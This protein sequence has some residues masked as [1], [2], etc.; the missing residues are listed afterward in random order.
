MDREEPSLLFFGDPK[1]PN[2]SKSNESQTGSLDLEL[3]VSF[4]L[5]LG[6]SE[7]NHRNDSARTNTISKD[8][9]DH[10]PTVCF[11]EDEDKEVFQ[12]ASDWPTR[13]GPPPQDAS[14]CSFLPG[15]LWSPRN[16]GIGK[17]QETPCKAVA[18]RVPLVLPCGPAVGADHCVAIKSLPSRTIGGENHRIYSRPNVVGLCRKQVEGERF[19]AVRRSRLR[20]TGKMLVRSQPI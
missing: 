17:I 15:S 16:Q 6:S 3:L 10:R 12:E 13:Q 11:L 2:C 19:A 20:V 18:L 9:I 5:R 1:G 14:P 7:R 8:G 4:L